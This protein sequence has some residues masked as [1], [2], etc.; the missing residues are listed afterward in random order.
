MKLV[1]ELP[2]ETGLNDFIEK[3]NSL[4]RS[5]GW[6]AGY[7]VKML[8]G[9]PLHGGQ[10]RT[11]F[12]D[13]G[14]NRRASDVVRQWRVGLLRRPTRW[15]AVVRQGRKQMQICGEG[16]LWNPDVALTILRFATG[17]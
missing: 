4:I 12:L 17:R 15:H 5:K 1:F 8:I 11:I 14:A 6:S 13:T 7:R 9:L 10:A 16:R 3:L 2:L